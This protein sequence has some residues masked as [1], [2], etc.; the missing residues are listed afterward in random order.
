MEAPRAIARESRSPLRIRGVAS[1]AA[2]RRGLLVA[3]GGH[4]S[5]GPLIV[6]SAQGGGLDSKGCSLQPVST[7][8]FCFPGF[9]DSKPCQLQRDFCQPFV[10]CTVARC[11]A[12]PTR[13]VRTGGSVA[14]NQACNSRRELFVPLLAGTSDR[15]T[16]SLAAFVSKDADVAV[17]KVFGLCSDPS[18][19]LSVLGSPL[20]SVG[21][22]WRPEAGDAAIGHMRRELSRWL[23]AFKED[24]SRAAELERD[25]DASDSKHH[26]ALVQ[27]THH[28]GVYTPEWRA[29]SG[30]YTPTLRESPVES[31]PEALRPD[32]GDAAIGHLRHELSRSIPAGKE[33]ASMRGAAELARDGDAADNKDAVASSP[34]SSLRCSLGSCSSTPGR[35]GAA[36]AHASLRRSPQGGRKM[37]PQELLQHCSVQRTLTS[38]HHSEKQLQRPSLE[39]KPSLHDAQWRS[40]LLRPVLPPRCSPQGDR[41]MA[42]DLSSPGAELRTP[43]IDRAPPAGDV[44]AP[45][46]LA[47]EARRALLSPQESMVAAGSPGSSKSV[48]PSKVPWAAGKPSLVAIL[49]KIKT[50]KVALE[51]KNPE[52]E[53]ME[54]TLA[55]WTERVDAV[56]KQNTIKLQM[57]IAKNS[58][59]SKQAQRQRCEKLDQIREESEQEDSSDGDADGT[60]VVHVQCDYIGCPAGKATMGVA[61]GGC[62]SRALNELAALVVA[63]MQILQGRFCAFECLHDSA[64]PVEA[65]PKGHDHFS[66]HGKV[67]MDRLRARFMGMQSRTAARSPAVKRKT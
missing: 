8:G 65:K 61:S 51:S 2:A 44:A 40:E 22:A 29:P 24:A 62:E 18:P 10:A 57:V 16:Q 45:S 56:R 7:P 42:A 1:Y 35:G 26:L 28:W 43:R 55:L 12:S 63:E 46:G 41:P 48:S 11:S 54:A 32:A 58:N 20:P 37:R 27:G 34:A 21:E 67:E 49:E 19:S 25:G 6:H 38:P 9:V 14:V 31:L 17:N 50:L 66:T 60:S 36:A 53:A 5:R 15:L 4:V 39:T 23:P 13:C 33:D 3:D 30:V 59:R 64:P 52:L 47:A